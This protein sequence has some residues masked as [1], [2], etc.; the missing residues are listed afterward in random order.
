MGLHVDQKLEEG[1]YYTET[2]GESPYNID[3]ISK[4]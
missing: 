1:S 2:N 4:N 3:N